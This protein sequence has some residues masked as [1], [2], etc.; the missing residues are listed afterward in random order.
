MAFSK[1]PLSMSLL[2]LVAGTVAIAGAW[3][4]D[5]P[6][7]TALDVTKNPSLHELAW[8][9][10]K[11]AEGWVPAVVGIFVA[12]IFVLAQRPVIG[13]KLFFVVITCEITGLAALILRILVGRTRPLASVPQGIYGVW[14]HGHWIIG[15]YQFS[16]FPSGHSATAV[17]LAAA[18]WLVHKGWGAVATVYALLVMWSRIALQCHHLSDVVASTALSIPLA[19]LCK[20]TL[21]PILENQFSNPCGW[22]RDSLKSW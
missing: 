4:L 8:W 9:C 2:W 16:S 17:G 6:V 12:A 15:K 10:S 20:N 21:L 22:K 5:G 13:A 3:T 7:D 19:I 1:S 14:Y 11:L 18:A